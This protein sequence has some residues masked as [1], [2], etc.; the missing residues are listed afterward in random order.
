M[1][2]SH[3]I[4]EGMWT[5]CN[6]EGFYEEI[7]FT[8]SKMFIFNEVSKPYIA[9]Y[10][11][12]IRNDSLIILGI[13]NNTFKQDSGRAKIN[14]LSENEIELTDIKNTSN[15]YK[16]EKRLIGR[17]KIP[18]DTLAF[19]K[20][21]KNIYENFENRRRQKECVDLRTDDE[22]EIEVEIGT[23]GVEIEEIM[24]VYEDSSNIK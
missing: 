17:D 15:Y 1:H 8:Q 22:K 5:S 11:Y 13:S 21:V 4:I 23:L 19:N 24:N 10:N 6:K 3:D 12:L 9:E 20:W 2:K 7:Q 14:V 18:K 16:L